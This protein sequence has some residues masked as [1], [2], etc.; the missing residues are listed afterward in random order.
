MARIKAIIV[1]CLFISLNFVFCGERYV[2]NGDGTVTDMKT[3]LMWAQKDSY[4]ETGQSLA[5]VQMKKY[6]AELRTGGCDDWRIPTLEQLK[7]L[8]DPVFSV[9]SCV[10]QDGV[11]RDLHFSPLFAAGGAVVYLSS[12]EKKK[13]YWFSDK[14]DVGFYV[15]SFANEKSGPI[16]VKTPA[17]PKLGCGIRAVRLANV[18]ALNRNVLNTQK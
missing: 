16:H 15:F 5:W 7:T 9:K 12:D 17:K 10:L 3:G 2:N 18:S 11:I 4:S 8:Y 14:N 1:V 6:V 13:P